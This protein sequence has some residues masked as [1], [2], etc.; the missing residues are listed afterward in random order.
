MFK[1]SLELLKAAFIKLIQ[2]RLFAV[3]IALTALFC[4]LTAKLIDLQIVNGDKYNADFI[5]S[6]ERTV[7]TPGAR[8]NIYDADGNLLAYNKLSY[9]DSS[10]YDKIFSDN[11]RG[12]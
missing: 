3:G 5:E 10:Q 6:I 8:G 1:E 12:K 11:C 7:R 4:V 2:S 9:N